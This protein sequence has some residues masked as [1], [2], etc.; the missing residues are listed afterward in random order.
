MVKNKESVFY[1]QC[2]KLFVYGSWLDKLD[3]ADK[4]M[5]SIKARNMFVV[6][7]NACSKTLGLN[8]KV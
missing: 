7:Y 6:D 8:E 2:K 1:P 3:K 4:I 5:Q